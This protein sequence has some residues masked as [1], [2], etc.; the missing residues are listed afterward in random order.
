MTVN[1]MVL[2]CSLLG[3]LVFNLGCASLWHELKP[4]RLWRLN[5]GAAP[6]LDP[7]FSY[8]PSTS[9]PRLAQCGAVSKDVT[10]SVNSNETVTVRSQSPLIE[11]H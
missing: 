2:L 10:V 5:R 11:A 9:R 4:H 8:R 1:R 6:S 7:E 3:S